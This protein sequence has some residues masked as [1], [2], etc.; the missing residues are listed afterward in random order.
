MQRRDLVKGALTLP[1]FARLNSWAQLCT[2]HGACNAPTKSFKLILRGPFG[3]ALHNP[4]TVT[5]ITAFVPVDPDG[6][7]HWAMERQ[8]QDNTK[9]FSFALKQSTPSSIPFCLDTAFQNFCAEKTTFKSTAKSKLLTIDLAIP[10]RITTFSSSDILTVDVK[11]GATGKKWYRSFVIEYDVSVSGVELTETASSV[12]IPTPNPTYT[13]EVGLRHRDHDTP[14]NAHAKKFY[15]ESLLPFFPDLMDDN[16]III[17]ATG[18]LATVTT[19]ECKAG[20]IIGGTSLKQP[21]LRINR[22]LR[23]PLLSFRR[24]PCPHFCAGRC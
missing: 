11:S 24:I 15:N 18:P 13:I 20:G 17:T 19:F 21:S 23:Y 2:G 10:A 12:I 14:D 1:A 16:H 7:H 8:P 5:G 3:L 6:R 9:Q 4:P 22:S